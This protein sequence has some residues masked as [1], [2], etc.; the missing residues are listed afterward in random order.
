MFNDKK[1]RIILRDTGNVIA[2]YSGSEWKKC[3][4]KPN[5]HHYNVR[6]V[7]KR[8]KL[9]TVVDFLFGNMASLN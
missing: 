4:L 9:F 3:R 5:I 1:M 7:L 6:L 8:K 2:K